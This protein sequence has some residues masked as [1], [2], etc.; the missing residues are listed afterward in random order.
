MLSLYVVQFNN[1]EVRIKLF[2]SNLFFIY[3]DTERVFSWESEDLV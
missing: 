1:K 3:C 2:Q